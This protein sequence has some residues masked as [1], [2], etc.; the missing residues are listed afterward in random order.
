M[1][2][3]PDEARGCRGSGAPPAGSFGQVARAAV[4]A[5]QLVL[6][7]CGASL[8]R[9]ADEAAEQGFTRL[10]LKGQPFEHVAWV[11]GLASRADVLHVYIEHDGVPWIAGRVASSDPTPLRP[12]MMRLMLE[13]PQPVLYLGRPCYF[14][15]H[16]RPPCRPEFWTDAR[17][18]PE[19][20]ESMRAA[21]L[22]I[23][24]DRPGVRVALF[25]HSGGAT[26]AALL[27]ARL[28]QVDT[29][30][31]IA[32][33]LDIAR[34][35]A[36]HGYSDLTGS[37]NPAAEPALPNRVHQRHYVGLAD[38]NTP[39]ELADRFSARQPISTVVKVPNADHDCCWHTL[40]PTILQEL[41]AMRTMR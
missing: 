18:S 41:R 14:G 11:R 28:P 23:L 19:V 30:V 26:L 29:L 17:Y 4:L 27:A 22:A 24:S 15:L 8:Q 13:D 38:R 37:L 16:A 7:G 12:V 21:L 3:T 9:S 34:W 40:W 39:P 5:C 35:T 10:T 20:V 32:G 31:T 36:L 6:V 25:G 2:R 1:R 33:N